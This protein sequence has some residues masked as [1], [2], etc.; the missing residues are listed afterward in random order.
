MPKHTPAFNEEQIGAIHQE[1]WTEYADH[2]ARLHIRRLLMQMGIEAATD[3]RTG[4]YLPHPYDQ[5]KLILKTLIGDVIKAVQNYTSRVAA[6]EPQASVIPVALNA[7]QVGKRVEERAAEQ[8]RLLMSMWEAVG[9]REAQVQS[10]WSQSWGRVGWY[11]TL[12][13]EAEW[14]LP[15]R[16]YYEDL[17]DD[18]ID[19]MQRS[20][21]IS[22]VPV[23]IDGKRVFPESAG[24]WLERRKAKA[25][26][27]AVNSRSFATLEAIP[28]DMVLVRYD[29]DGTARK[30]IKYAFI[31]EEHPASDFAPGSE[32][33]KAAARYVKRH[34][35][36]EQRQMSDDEIARYGMTFKDGKIA[37][38]VS[39]GVEPLGVQG[40]KWFLSRFLTRDEVYWFVSESAGASAGTII[41]H[42]YHGGGKVPL[43]PVPGFYTDSMSPGNEYSS[44]MEDVFT[45]TPAINQLET[46]LS[47]VATWNALGRFVVEIPE[48]AALFDDEGEPTILK[49]EEIIPGAEPGEV[50][51]IRGKVRQLE[52]GADLLLQMLEF[53][54]ERLDSSKPAPVTEGQTGTSQA[55]WAVRLSLDA[56]GEQLE[57]SVDNHAEAVK[58]VMLLWIRWLRLYD[59]P[60]YSFAA[61]GRRGSG[62]TVRGLIEFNPSDLIETI[63]INQSSQSIQQRIVLDQAG[64]EKL[65]AGVID[66]EEYYELYALAA[67][68]QEARIRANAQKVVSLL[69]TGSS[70]E[71]MPGSLLSDVA[72]AVRGRISFRLLAQGPEFSPAFAM[73]TAEDMAMQSLALQSPEGNPALAAGVR[74]PGINMG[75]QQP[76]TPTDQA[77]AGVV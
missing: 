28:P 12:P 63:T 27:N 31:V 34:G 45:L 19:I 52:V 36:D 11:H 74:Q 53:F 58:Q 56:A 29:R 17:T 8:E 21:T 40:S 73:S 16:E 6:N 10:T 44:L 41:H 4:A 13:R 65:Q 26:D 15:D 71:I 62:N 59:E 60:V 22:T 23:D 25:K 2:F 35:T 48:G 42:Q 37:G 38:G 33:A 50:T 14:G 18:E 1:L 24:N 39:A 70:E 64:I 69:L 47:N 61:P 32:M 57:Q 7:S 3:E 51:S 43:I 46:L 49:R 54:T 77:P 9:G 72:Q 75:L 67:D 55:A 5:S 76:G 66:E 20:G 30:S 68:P